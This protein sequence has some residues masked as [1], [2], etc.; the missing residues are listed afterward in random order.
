MIPQLL[1]NL[2]KSDYLTPFIGLL[3]VAF[4]FVYLLKNLKGLPVRKY[5]GHLTY[6]NQEQIFYK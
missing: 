3:W 6:A 4:I 2:Y 5:K 1:T